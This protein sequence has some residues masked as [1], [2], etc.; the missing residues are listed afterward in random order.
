MQCN[1]SYIVVFLNKTAL[2]AR[3]ISG[4]NNRSYTLVWNNTNSA[5][6]SVDGDDGSKV[7]AWCNGLSNPISY[8]S[9]ICTG[10]DL[11][12]DKC[13]LS[14]ASNNDYIYYSQ[15]LI[16]TY[17]EN[18]AANIVRE[19]RDVYHIQ[20]F[21][22]RTIE[23]KLTGDS[24]DVLSRSDGNATGSKFESCFHIV[25]RFLLFQYSLHQM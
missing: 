5:V 19:E 10:I 18:P 7:D 21:F 24:F 14:I 1:D 6:C 12:K 15:S 25:H 20:C 8:V 13:G 4:Y 22:N 11:A 23:K 16:V 17:G 3:T 2:D 9:T